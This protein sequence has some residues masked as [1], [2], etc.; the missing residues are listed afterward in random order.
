M[1]RRIVFDPEANEQDRLHSGTSIVVRDVQ[2]DD[3]T[4]FVTDTPTERNGDTDRRL[5]ALQELASE[6]SEVGV[7]FRRLAENSAEAF[8]SLPD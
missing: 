5:E 3:R 4:S 7:R 2:A 1:D 8:A 6:V